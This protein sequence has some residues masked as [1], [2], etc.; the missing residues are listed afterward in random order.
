MGSP[1]SAWDK[2]KVTY[3]DFNSFEAL[4]EHEHRIVWF[5][6]SAYTQS[7]C[8]FTV[9]F[10]C[11]LHL[12]SIH[13]HENNS[14]PQ[15]QTL[16]IPTSFRGFPAREYFTEIKVFCRIHLYAIPITYRYFDSLF[17]STS[18]QLIDG[19]RC[20]IFIYLR[21]RVAPRSTWSGAVKC[22]H[23]DSPASDFYLCIIILWDKWTNE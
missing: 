16:W 21:S 4:W 20:M 1:P 22:I 5:G 7:S 18:S 6:L 3:N 9:P 10:Q 2:R 8:Q 19:V 14:W 12:C 11:Q 15:N 17:I 13:E 23:E